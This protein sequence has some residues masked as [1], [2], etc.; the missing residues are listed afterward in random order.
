MRT[1]PYS[2]RLR[3]V[4]VA[5]W[6]FA[7]WLLIQAGRDTLLNTIPLFLAAKTVAGTV[8]LTMGITFWELGTDRRAGVILDSKGIMFNM[9]YYA[10]F[11]AW[12]NIA[13][14]GVTTHRSSLLSLGSPRQL[15]ITFYDPQ[16]FLQSY[17]ERLPASRGPLGKTLRL[18]ARVLRP[19]SRSS[20]E[21]SPRSLERMR[22]KTGYDIVVPEALLGM[23][24]TA[25]VE[26]VEGY[27]Q[28]QPLAIMQTASLPP[29]DTQQPTL[30]KR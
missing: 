27:W 2:A 1:T 8:L 23:S 19:F 26:V 6:L 29:T 11:V 13:T 30:S 17:E 28:N 24:A 18:L 14:I 12:A 7:G 5:C 20:S 4:A 3:V 15:G 16:T 9:G 10:A 25:F 21:I 22:Q